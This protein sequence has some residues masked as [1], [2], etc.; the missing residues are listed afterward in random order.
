MAGSIVAVLMYITNGQCK[1]NYGSVYEM[2]GGDF[3]S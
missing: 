2:E 3:T 1:A